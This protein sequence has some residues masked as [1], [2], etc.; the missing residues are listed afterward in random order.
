V[1]ED[2]NITALGEE[3]KKVKKKIRFGV[4]IGIFLLCI[5]LFSAFLI[6]VN[7]SL[8]GP[9]LLGFY[10]FAPFIVIV[11]VTLPINRKMRKWRQHEAELKKRLLASLHPTP[12]CANCGKPLV[13]GNTFCSYCGNKR[14]L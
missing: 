9:N 10:L 6:V 12:N 13:E 8:Y 14:Q 3:I 11:I 1:S 2:T 4:V 5:G 7:A